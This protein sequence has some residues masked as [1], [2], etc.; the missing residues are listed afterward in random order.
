MPRRRRGASTPLTSPSD[1]VLADDALPDKF[2]T[3]AAQPLAAIDAAQDLSTPLG[4]HPP[5]NVFSNAAQPRLTAGGARGH[6]EPHVTNLPRRLSRAH[7]ERERIR[8]RCLQEF[9]TGS[10][11]W[12]AF[13]AEFG[14]GDH[15]DDESIDGLT[16]E[17]K[18]DRDWMW[19]ERLGFTGVIRVLLCRSHGECQKEVKGQEGEEEL[20]LTIGREQV[21]AYD[22]VGI[23][24]LTDS[25]LENAAAFLIE[26]RRRREGNGKVLISVPPSR[27]VEALSVALFTLSLP[28]TSSLS[29]S[30][31]P[32]P[33]PSYLSQLR[34]LPGI[35][36]LE[37]SQE[38][39]IDVAFDDSESVEF[40]RVKG[41]PKYTL[42]QLALWHIHDLPPAHPDEEH[43]GLKSEWRGALSLDGI[44]KLESLVA[45]R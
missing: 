8:R 4:F 22:D 7:K 40:A 33:S 39:D 36:E 3:P 12:I 25:Q 29:S 24:V 13:N 43:G 16:E 15:D 45:S 19:E 41:H 31:S 20:Q 44:E 6:L 18:K 34:F 1:A 30:P 28:S 5:R 26:S 42:I 21:K 23:S 17:E 10:G 2:P 9:I 27:P 37:Q 11:V 38:I 35:L 14:S 32:H